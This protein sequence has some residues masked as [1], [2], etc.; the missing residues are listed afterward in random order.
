M[1]RTD[2]ADA[3]ERRAWDAWRVAAARPLIDAE[4]RA[5]YAEV[6][7]AI[8]ARG[9]T[10]WVSGKC[11]KFE[12]FGHRL[13][14]TALEVAWFVRQVDAAG[15]IDGDGPP[16]PDDRARGRSGGVCLP[17]LAETAGACPYQVAGRCS[18]HAVRPLGCRIFFCQAGTEDWQ[19]DL[20]E[21][22]LVRLRALHDRH[23]LE[24]RYLDWM[25]GLERARP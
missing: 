17:Q 15:P 2:A 16:A 21:T 8:A 24:Y 13:Y 14:V 22:F 10:C 19:Q 9:P 18:T 7:A 1:R 11:C 6:D 4:L 20:Y 23:G 25:V 5:I 3:D 12:T